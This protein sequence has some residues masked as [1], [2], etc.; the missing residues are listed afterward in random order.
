MISTG[1]DNAN[2][3]PVAIVP[4]GIPI[5]D[6]YAVPRVQIIYRTL[7]VYFPNLG[8]KDD[9]SSRNTMKHASHF[10]IRLVGH[11][12]ST[13]TWMR[14]VS[15]RGCLSGSQPQHQPFQRSIRCTC[16]QSRSQQLSS[17]YRRSHGSVHG[18]P[19]NLILRAGLSDNTLI[20][21]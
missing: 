7:L 19:P 12:Q 4:P 21:G 8:N 16:S 18:P 10:L 17:T 20:Q 13:S 2:I 14:L 11:V 5:D 3:D 15:M 6:V 9:I 1:A